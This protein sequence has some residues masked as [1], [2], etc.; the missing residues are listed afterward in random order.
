MGIFA[1]GAHQRMLW[2]APKEVL[3]RSIS[4]FAAQHF[5]KRIPVLVGIDPIVGVQEYDA[6]CTIHALDLHVRYMI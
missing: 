5:S 6:S 2:C 3:L 4:C 1:F